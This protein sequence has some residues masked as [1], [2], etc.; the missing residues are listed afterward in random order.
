MYH[1]EDIHIYIHIYTYIYIYICRRIHANICIY[2]YICKVRESER[3]TYIYIY[4]YIYG[5]ID[6]CVYVHIFDF[7]PLSLYIYIYIYIIIIGPSQDEPHT[8]TMAPTMALWVVGQS[9]HDQHR[10]LWVPGKAGVKD[11]IQDGSDTSTCQKRPC[12]ISPRAALL[13]SVAESSMAPSC[14]KPEN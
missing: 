11:S 1:Y 9:Y 14:K 2:I 10:D 5:H 13:G 6:I 8:S 7:P 4:M 3:F 12:P